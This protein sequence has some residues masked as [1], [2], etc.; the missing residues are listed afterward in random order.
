MKAE[1]FAGYSYSHDL[2]LSEPRV[3]CH[4]RSCV[5]CGGQSGNEVGFL[6]I[7]RLL[8]QLLI[9]QTAPYLLIIQSP[10]LYCLDT[11]SVVK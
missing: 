8:F 6:R 3:R 2:M 9:P 11:E 10:T 4:V 5:I 1:T 7:L